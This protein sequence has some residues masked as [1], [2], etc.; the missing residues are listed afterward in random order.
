MHGRLGYA[1]A[2]TTRQ[3]LDAQ[4]DSLAEAR[5]TR[6]F[7]EKISTRAT[8]RRGLEAAVRL[9]AALTAPR[10]LGSPAGLPAQA[11]CS[12]LR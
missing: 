5:V 6:V 12:P 7:P 4:L 2:S 1:R 3:P 9:T 11:R 10:C 8:R